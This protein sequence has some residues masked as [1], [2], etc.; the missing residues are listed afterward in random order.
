MEVVEETEMELKENI[1]SRQKEDEF[2]A[3]EI[4]R[5]QEGRNSEFTLKP[6]DESLWYH[7]RIC[8]PDI[9]EI[10]NL[11]LKEAHETPYS[12]H[13]GSTKNVYGFEEN[14]LVEQYEKRNC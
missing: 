7:S 3:E 1:L 5:I 6:E 11:I 9:K 12:I 13:P 10:K 8:V 2:L 14:I 4:R